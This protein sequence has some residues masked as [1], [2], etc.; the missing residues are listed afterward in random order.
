MD[1]FSLEYL[2]NYEYKHYKGDIWKNGWHNGSCSF[3]HLDCIK[4]YEVHFD[5]NNK[6]NLRRID[7]RHSKWEAERMSI[8]TKQSD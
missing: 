6:C 3:C 2:E 1:I 7:Y 4:N 8:Y 5:S